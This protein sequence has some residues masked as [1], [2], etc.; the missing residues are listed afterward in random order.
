[1]K[2]AN[3]PPRDNIELCKS[4]DGENFL[5]TGFAGIFQNENFPVYPAAKSTVCRK[6]LTTVSGGHLR[7]WLNT[8]A[9]TPVTNIVNK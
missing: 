7:V 6:N 1:M 9:L 4:D 3:Q 2:N 5:P 8:A